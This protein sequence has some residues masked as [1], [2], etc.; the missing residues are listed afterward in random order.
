MCNRFENT[1]PLL[2]VRPD[3]IKPHK[4]KLHPGRIQIATHYH[5][6]ESG[7]IDPCDLLVVDEAH[8]A[9][10]ENSRF[11]GTSRSCTRGES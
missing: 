3:R 11:A 5:A 10:G 4:G 1:P 9:K 8:R 7:K 6:A 2:N